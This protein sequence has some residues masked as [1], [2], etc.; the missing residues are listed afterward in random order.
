MK[1]KLLLILVSLFFVSLIYSQSIIVKESIIDEVQ[2]ISKEDYPNAHS[3]LVENLITY[4]YKED[5]TSIETDDTYIKI[6]DQKGKKNNQKQYFGYDRNYSDFNLKKV[7]IIKESGEII[8]IDIEK[9]T[10]D[11]VDP[12]QTRMN[13]YEKSSRLVTLQ[14]PDLEI[15]D[16]LHYSSVTN[17]KKARVKGDFSFFDIAE[18][19]MPIKHLKVVVKGPKEKPL[20]YFKV[21]DKVKGH[22]TKNTKVVEDKNVYTFEAND[23]DKIIRE[24]SMPSIA[25]VGMRVIGTT[26]NNWEELSKWYYDLTEPKMDTT[27]EMK[28]KAEELVEGKEKDIEKVRAIF[29]FVQTIRY[30]GA[31]KEDNRPGLE[32]HKVSYTFENKVGVCRD[33]AALIVAML[34]SLGF[35]SHMVLINASRKLDKEVPLTYFNHAIAQVTLKDGEKILMDPTVETSNKFFPAWEMDKSYLVAKKDGDIL[36]VTPIIPAED[37]LMAINTD[38]KYKNGEFHCTSNLK[39]YGVNDDAYRSLFVR[40]NKQQR[41][42]FINRTLKGISQSAKLINYEIKPVNLMGSN[43]NLELILEYTVKN[44]IVENNDYG[45][46]KLPM[47]SNSFGFYN[48]LLRPTR[49]KERNYPL[50]LMITASIKENINFEYGG[51]EIEYIKIPEKIGIKKSGMR[52]RTSYLTEDKNLTVKRFMALDKINYDVNEYKQLKE[53]LKKIENYENKYIIFSK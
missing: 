8:E 3:V 42:D 26:V 35:E 52:Y 25:N 30:M 5:G 39:F 40:R 47:I 2:K 23:V 27:E 46:F 20:K 51:E 48:F 38:I 24:P 9:N 50:K 12:S 49:L 19:F 33:K 7:E 28:K 32:P 37:N 14:I 44:L 43:E 10:T 1:K 11:Q 15:G 36:K 6:I 22:F 31:A 17:V 4:D 53:N 18:Y 41:D 21:F 16:T 34:R 29:N 13:I 45:M